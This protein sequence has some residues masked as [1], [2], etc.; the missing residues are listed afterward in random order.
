[1]KKLVLLAIVS[2]MLAASVAHAASSSGPGKPTVTLHFFDVTTTSTATIS[3]N[4]RPKL[5]DRFFSHDNVYNWNGA[6]RGALVGQANTTFVVLAPNLG[7]VSGVASLP[8]GTLAIEGQVSFNGGPVS[9]FPVIGGTGRYVTAR[10][11]V[12]V[13]GIGGQN[14]NKSAVTV[15]LWM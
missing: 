5:G 1:M 11:E 8:G 14:S 2:A 3:Q 9:T 4:Q 15:R 13:R 10:G 7:E 6:K 12:I